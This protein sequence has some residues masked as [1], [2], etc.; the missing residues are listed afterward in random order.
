MTNVNDKW[1]QIYV[2]EAR[3][4]PVTQSWPLTYIISEEEKTQTW[5]A[6]PPAAQQKNRGPPAGHLNLL[7][8]K[9]HTSCLE[10]SLGKICKLGT[11][12]L[13][14]TRTFSARL[15]GLS[16]IRTWKTPN[17]TFNQQEDANLKKKC[18]ILKKTFKHK[19]VTVDADN[20]L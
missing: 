3:G 10:E 4:L 5:P 7:R 12:I 11:Q 16:L 15:N 1:I 17:T 6:E 9:S 2:D 8:S 20:N 13:P 19:T 14:K 18:F